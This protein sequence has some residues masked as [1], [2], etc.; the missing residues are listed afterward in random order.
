MGRSV[1]LSHASS[2]DEASIEQMLIGN[3]AVMRSTQDTIKHVA[4][5]PDTTVLL[6]GESGTGKEVAARAIHLLSRRASHQFSPSTVPL[7]Q[8]RFSKQ[9]FLVS[10]REHSPMQKRRVMV[11]SYELTVERCSS[12]KLVPCHSRC[13]PSCSA[14]WKRAVSAASGGQKNCMSICASSLRQTST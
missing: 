6:Q 13:R 3:S 1:S 9:N 5:Y 14:F 2:Q 10:R 7:F 11:T 4:H 8:I 12:T